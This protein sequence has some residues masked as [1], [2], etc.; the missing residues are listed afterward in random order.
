MEPAAEAT[1]L[2]TTNSDSANMTLTL[3]ICLTP[4]YAPFL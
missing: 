4:N 3:V 1:T 2:P